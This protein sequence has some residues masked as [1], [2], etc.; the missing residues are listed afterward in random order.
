M[1][2]IDPLEVTRRGIAGELLADPTIELSELLARYKWAFLVPAIKR[3]LRAEVEDWAD[4]Y[5]LARPALYLH[6]GVILIEDIDSTVESVA[7]ARERQSE[8][9]ERI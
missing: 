7:A 2:D 9:F 6:R 8:E 4:K 5:G 3:R 1:K